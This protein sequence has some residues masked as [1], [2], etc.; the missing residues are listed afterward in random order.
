MAPV[1]ESRVASLREKSG[2][3]CAAGWKRPRGSKD[4]RGKRNACGL[5]LL[6]Q[7]GPITVL[8]AAPQ[9]GAQGLG[10]GID[11]QRGLDAH[12]LAQLARKEQGEQVLH[13]IA[14]ALA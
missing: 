2:G 4:P 7:A 5:L 13:Q 6:R 1:R 10:M 12:G 8:Q 9:L 11:R 3:A 14:A